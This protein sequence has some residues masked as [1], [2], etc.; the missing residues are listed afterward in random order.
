MKQIGRFALRE[1]GDLVNAYYA[2]PETMEG[3]IL[4]FSVKR[5]AAMLPG[6]KEKVLALGRQIVGE[7]IFDVTGTRLSWPNEPQPAPEHERSGR[8]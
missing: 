5:G 8:A 7:I 4:L 1:E 6:V 2:M 3:A